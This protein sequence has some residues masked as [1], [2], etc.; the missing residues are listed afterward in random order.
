MVSPHNV[1]LTAHLER[2]EDATECAWWA[3]A[4]ELPGFVAAYPSLGELQRE[5]ED[6]VCF[7]LASD[8]IEI[9]WK[10][11]EGVPDWAYVHIEFVRPAF[12]QEFSGRGQNANVTAGATALAQ[13][14]GAPHP[15]TSR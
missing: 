10:A 3:E 15:L 6:A 11:A 8:D 1:T 2:S 7:A 5:A 4:N 14:S 9:E 12:A 13:V